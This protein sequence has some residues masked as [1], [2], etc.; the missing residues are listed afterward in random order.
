MVKFEVGD[1]ARRA[2][3]RLTVHP[4]NEADESFSPWEE[5]QDVVSLVGKS[6]TVNLDETDI[7]GPGIKTELAE[8]LGVKSWRSRLDGRRV[9]P[10][11]KP[12][13]G[14]MFRKHC[15]YFPLVVVYTTNVIQKKNR[16]AAESFKPRTSARSVIWP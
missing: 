7:V 10:F 9:S 2:A 15:H 1:G 11:L 8:P 14:R 6:R 13:N 5:T 3:N 4:A 12:F 16:R